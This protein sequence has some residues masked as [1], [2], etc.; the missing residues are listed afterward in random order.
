FLF[1]PIEYEGFVKG[2]V[3]LFDDLTEKKRLERY[4]HS[5]EKLASLGELSMRL[6]HEIRNPLVAIKGSAEVLIEDKE[7]AQ[8]YRGELFELIISQSEKLSNIIEDF[9]RFARTGTQE[10]GKLTSI[11]LKRILSSI[12]DNYRKQQGILSNTE[13]F[14][15]LEL[16]DEI[17]VLGERNLLEQAFK[18]IIQNSI[19]SI[20]KGKGLIRIYLEPKSVAVGEDNDYIGISVEDNG[21]GIEENKIEE[22]FKPFYTTKTG[23]IGL[24]L[25][26]AQKAIME[27]G[28]IITVESKL[29]IGSKFTVYLRRA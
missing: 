18:N 12:V 22:I 1:S 3:V 26:I 23:G 20:D 6:A 7:L 29:G 14:F 15:Q 28:G 4:I 10:K 24:G 2:V 19:Q 9:L 25:S 16:P 11:P 17:W 8:N 5:M 27:M 21:C 13:L